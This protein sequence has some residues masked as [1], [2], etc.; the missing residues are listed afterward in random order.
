M[1]GRELSANFLNFEIKFEGTDRMPSIMDKT[2]MLLK[3]IIVKYQTC[4]KK[5]FYNLLEGRRG[6]IIYKGLKLK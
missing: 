5:R 1:E 2:R 6:C 4:D 3:H